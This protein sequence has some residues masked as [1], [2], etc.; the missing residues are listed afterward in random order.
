MS[1]RESVES[2]ANFAYLLIGWFV[3]T[4]I[5]R[6]V[7]FAV[8]LIDRLFNDCWA[9]GDRHHHLKEVSSALS[10]PRLTARTLCHDTIDQSTKPRKPTEVTVEANPL[11]PK[12]GRGLKL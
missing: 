7:I 9:S 8:M 1:A 12:R 3:H 10:P 6:V 2:R 11:L 4:F 5:Y